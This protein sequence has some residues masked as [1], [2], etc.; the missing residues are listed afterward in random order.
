MKLRKL[1]LQGHSPKR[2]LLKNL[3][4]ALQMSYL[5]NPFL[6]EDLQ[7]LKSPLVS[8]FWSSKK[9]NIDKLKKLLNLSPRHTTSGSNTDRK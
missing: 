8:G 5:H 9:D 6:K 2:T 3:G 4:E 1:K 7:K